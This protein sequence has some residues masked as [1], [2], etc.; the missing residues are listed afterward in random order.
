M[1]LLAAAFSAMLGVEVITPRQAQSSQR[2]ELPTVSVHQLFRATYVMRP[3]MAIEQSATGTSQ[4]FDINLRTLTGTKIIIPVINDHTIAEIKA[5]VEQKEGVSATRQRL[6]FNSN[7]LKDEDTVA[8]LG[9]PPLGT[10]G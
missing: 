1:E 3:R 9:I 4:E 7:I 10:I 6:V 5:A 2:A 8:G